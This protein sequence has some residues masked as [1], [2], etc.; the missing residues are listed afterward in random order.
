MKDQ[1]REIEGFTLLK[2]QR[3]LPTYRA[4]D[5][6]PVIVIHELYG[7]TPEVVAFARKLVINGFSVWLPVLVGNSP[8]TSRRDHAR[9]VAAICVSRE[10]NTF[11]RGKTSPVVDKLRRLVADA[12]VMSQADRVGVVGMCLSG[13]FAI[14]LA[15][16]API[17]GAVAAQPSLPFG[18]PITPWCQGALGMSQDECDAVCLRLA[19]GA[20]ELYVTRF[21][22]D[23]ISPRRR[24]AAIRDRFGGPGLTVDPIDSDRGNQHGFGRRDHS[25]LSVA[26][27]RHREPQ[28]L[29]R[30]EQAYD[31][32]VAFLR[33]RLAG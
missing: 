18:L 22:A 12:A 24:E 25:V 13:G 26:P 1:Q 31:D 16:E 15:A 11:A 2:P 3:A 17:A 32:V 28:A 4:G 19:S 6:P 23:W 30:L 33:H 8:S 7:L 29:A 14:S 5:G 21:S 10:I 9:A 20:V 27:S